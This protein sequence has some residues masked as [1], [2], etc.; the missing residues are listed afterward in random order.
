MYPSFWVVHQD[1]AFFFF[2]IFSQTQFFGRS[3]GAPIPES[4]ECHNLRKIRLLAPTIGACVFAVFFSTTSFHKRTA[5]LFDS[6]FPVA[7]KIRFETPPRGLCYHAC[8]TVYRFQDN[9]GI[10][11]SVRPV[12]LKA[13]CGLTLL[14]LVKGSGRSRVST[15]GFDTSRPGVA[16]LN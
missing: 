2:F 13:W 15:G 8:N 14:V 4:S 12:V 3:Y 7:E 9:G 6:I 10:S 16:L 5:R 1:C 11:L